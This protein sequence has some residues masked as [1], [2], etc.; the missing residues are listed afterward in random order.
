MSELRVF[1]N[2]SPK[3]I[4]GKSFRRNIMIRRMCTTIFL[5]TLC[6]ANV[7]TQEPDTSSAP[8]KINLETIKSPPKR[9]IRF[10]VNNNQPIPIG[11]ME[12]V[13]ALVALKR[14]LH[15][16]NAISTANL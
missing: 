4:N 1:D 16:P 6:V 15:E 3:S 5:L 10:E 2:N 14:N 7:H 13:F 8:P 9:Q 12:P 11:D